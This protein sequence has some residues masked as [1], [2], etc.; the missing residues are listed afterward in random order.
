MPAPGTIGSLWGLPFCIGVSH[1]DR[2]AL[3]ILACVL[4]LILAVRLASRGAQVLG[5][6]K[7][8]QAIVIDEI[9]ALPVAFL[10]VG[11]LGW[12][13]LLLG[14]LLFRVFD[15]LKPPPCKRAEQLPGGWG[16]VAD[17]VVAAVYAC[18][19]LHTAIWIDSTFALQFLH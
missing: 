17:D 5:G 15:I 11:A 3:Q 4:L 19:I 14:W 12:K 13:K 8:P 7:D 2:S 10:G 9:A 6:T 18:L 1:I 16:I